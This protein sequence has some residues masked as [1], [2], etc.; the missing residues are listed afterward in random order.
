MINNF[1]F[2]L[3]FKKIPIFTPYDK[4]FLFWNLIS[5]LTTIFL[6]F[7]I[8]IEIAFE[9]TVSYI[10]PLILLVIH[11]LDISIKLNTANFLEGK[12]FF[13]RKKIIE[14]YKNNDFFLDFVIF[15]VIIYHFIINLVFIG[16]FKG[17]T[18]MNLS[19]LKLMYFY[20]AKKFKKIY[21]IL[22]E[23][24][25]FQEKFKGIFKL[26]HLLFFLLIYIHIFA[27]L[28][29]KIGFSEMR[30]DNENWIDSQGI[31]QES[32][33]KKYIFSF[34]W[35]S[36]TIMTVG[37]GDISPKNNAEMVFSIVA[38][39]LGC[40]IYAYNL[41]SIGIILQEVYKKERSCE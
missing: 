37:Y 7:L 15:F 16:N 10:F 6:L 33:F 17:E 24:F 32:F 39:V 29:Y 3:L 19:F 1:N 2:F 5:I 12:L 18:F 9:E 26:F 36:V 40:G 31:S 21:Q 34:Y 8:P 27:C 20:R 41:N 35:A 30:K 13:N 28:W 23:L 25:G 14:F 38:I 11:I 22:E 4:F